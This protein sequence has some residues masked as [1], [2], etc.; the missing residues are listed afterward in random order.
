M[1]NRLTVTRVV[2]QPTAAA[3]DLATG[4][5]LLTSATALEAPAVPSA[6]L[7]MKFEKPFAAM[8]SATLM[9]ALANGVVTDFAELAFSRSEPT[10][11]GSMRGTIPRRA[12]VVGRV[13]SLQIDGTETTKGLK[14]CSAATSPRA[15]AIES[16]PV[17]R[18]ATIKSACLSWL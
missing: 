16:A 2:T 9:P 1:L 11:A 13:G 18:V 8:I 14:F 4:A 7:V 6:A 12:S 10:T 15:A 17:P 5:A 3:A